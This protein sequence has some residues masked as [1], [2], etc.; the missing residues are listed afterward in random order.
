MDLKLYWPLYG[1]LLKRIANRKKINSKEYGL[2]EKLNKWQQE[3]YEDVF[4][5]NIYDV[6]KNNM[7][8]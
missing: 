4:L 8:V 1:A 5:M 6:L 7:I 3:N 2:I